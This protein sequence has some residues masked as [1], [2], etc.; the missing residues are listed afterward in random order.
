[1]A[2]A[3]VLA[4]FGAVYG[5]ARYSA[6][7]E[8]FTEKVPEWDV[9]GVSEGGRTLT[10]RLHTGD[11]TCHSETVGASESPSTARI[12]RTRIGTRRR[13]TDAVKVR[14]GTP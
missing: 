11:R 13:L 9:V 3:A 12:S 5:L 8:E 2:A 7:H 14:R 4:A 1:V 6:A 10:I